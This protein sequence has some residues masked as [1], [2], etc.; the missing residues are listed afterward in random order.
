MEAFQG[1]MLPN[2]TSMQDVRREA[3]TY[4]GPDPRCA[5]S[6]PV[7]GAVAAFHEAVASQQ[8]EVEAIP[9]QPTVAE[10]DYVA[11]AEVVA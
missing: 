2:T 1:M 6:A 8:A 9:T 7:L 11:P 10:H 3:P 5:K 4:W